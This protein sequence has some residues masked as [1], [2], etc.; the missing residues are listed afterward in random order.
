[1]TTQRQNIKKER[2]YTPKSEAQ[3]LFKKLQTFD[4]FV[5]ATEFLEPSAGEGV[6]LNVMPHPYLVRAKAYDLD[7]RHHLAVQANYLEKFVP[8]KEGRVAIGNPPFGRR[9]SLSTAFINKLAKECDYICF[10]LPLSYVKD[11]VQAS[12][13]PHL[14]LIYEEVLGSTNFTGPDAGS[15]GVKCVFQVWKREDF[16][17]KKPAIKLSCDD[18]KFVSDKK[19]ADFAVRTHGS[20]VGQIN[21]PP[22]GKESKS[23][24]RLVKVT[25]DVL[26]AD[27]VS[28]FKKMGIKEKALS[29]TTKQPCV[30]KRDLVE[31]YQ[32]LQ[33]Q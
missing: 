3:R 17:R 32:A 22:T 26:T 18:F 2:F 9:G 8:Y 27:V 29:T 6:W 7:P 21:Y 28:V 1:M 11:S 23:T 15:Q 14:H 31:L 33:D 30:G 20:S 10:I 13:D 25:G 4:W 5:N 12:I 24:W 19:D 16:E